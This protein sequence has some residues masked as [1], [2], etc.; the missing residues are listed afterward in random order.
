MNFDVLQVDRDLSVSI[1]AVS[2]A[3][4]SDTLTYQVVVKNGGDSAANA[5][6]VS[7]L[8]SPWLSNLRISNIA[9]T[10]G[11]SSSL[12][13]PVSLGE[14]AQV[15]AVNLPAGGTVTYTISGVVVN[16]QAS[17]LAED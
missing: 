17:V 11:A 16:P 2:Q 10:P 5:A 12:S 14:S 1:E 13:A 9:T 4:L 8:G 3:R 7:L 15:D 6:Q